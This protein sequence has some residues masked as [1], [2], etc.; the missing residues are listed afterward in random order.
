M[1]FICCVSDLS[2]LGFFSLYSPPKAH[3]T[4]FGLQISKITCIQKAEGCHNCI[5]WPGCCSACLCNCFI[6]PIQLPILPNHKTHGSI[7]S[8]SLCIQPCEAIRAAAFT[9]DISSSRVAV[10]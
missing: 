4:A 5:F 10:G 2:F 6:L 1:G 3:I 9:V 7:W 8:L